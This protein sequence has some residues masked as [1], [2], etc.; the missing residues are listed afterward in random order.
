[1]WIL[2][3]KSYKLKNAYVVGTINVFKALINIILSVD[4]IRKT[5][6][7]R[8]FSANIYAK[9]VTN[10]SP[11]AKILLSLEQSISSKY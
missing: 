5:F 7:L 1:L 4:K 2:V 11:D 10:F 8:F 3:L 9:K 6:I